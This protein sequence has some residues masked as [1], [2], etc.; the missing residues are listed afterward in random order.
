VN[1]LNPDDHAML[2]HARLLLLL[3]VTEETAPEG[4]DAERLGLYDFLAVHPLLLAR[5]EDDPDRL[6]LRLAGFD[7]RAVA[8][9]S[10][11][12]RFVSAQLGLPRD[13]AALIG[14]GLVSV[15]AGGRIRY[16]TTAEGKR[17]ASQFT[18]MYAQTYITAAR[19]VVRRT[20]RLS[21]R[22][23]RENLREWLTIGPGQPGTQLHPAY[24]LDS[25]HVQ[26]PSAK[27]MT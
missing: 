10:P 27:D 3:T 9:A 1:A 15:T 7:E 24:L 21:G 23:L 6:A 4:V 20:R 26:D 18:A 14:Q 8:Y 11:A 12:Q 22:K 5:H 2:R 17:V 16:R 13:L 25:E 19:V